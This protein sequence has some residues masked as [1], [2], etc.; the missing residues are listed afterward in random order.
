[1]K[2]I[3]NLVSAFAAS[4]IL[5]IGGTA[6]AKTVITENTAGKVPIIIEHQ[7]DLTYS[8]I[9]MSDEL[10]VGGEV[11]FAPFL[12]SLPNKLSYIA[13]TF[14]PGATYPAHS[15]PDTYVVMIT[16]GS[17]DM[18]TYVLDGPE[19]KATTGQTLTTTTSFVAGDTIVFRPDVVH[20]WEAGT[21]GFKCLVTVI[22]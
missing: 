15:G 9:T 19:G 3:A 21:T 4:G 22:P 5:L 8:P 20:G 10:P 18:F 11:A 14:G 16:E 2:R 13:F 12:G 17:G 6:V 1:M 7:K